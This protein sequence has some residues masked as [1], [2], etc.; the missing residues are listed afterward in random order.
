MKTQTITY[1]T[2]ASYRESLG[3]SA[4]LNFVSRELANEHI[5]KE[6]A[7][8]NWTP[9]VE[10]SNVTI[11]K[12]ERVWV[13]QEYNTYFKSDPK[14]LKKVVK[15]RVEQDKYTDTHNFQGYVSSEYKWREQVNGWGRE[16]P[17]GYYEFKTGDLTHEITET[18]VLFK[19]PVYVQFIKAELIV[20]PEIKEDGKPYQVRKEEVK[21][22]VVSDWL[23]VYVVEGGNWCSTK[24][25]I[26]PEWTD[27]SWWKGASLYVA[28][29][30][31][32]VEENKIEIVTNLQ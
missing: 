17:A 30:E 14:R 15:Q 12:K 24:Y 20:T 31:Y 29:T 16:K 7:P 13:D 3:K 28:A 32:Y 10:L 2:L 22:E 6:L 18:G 19:A 21:R 23:P 26:D 25:G 8:K 11:T 1:Y 5:I 4:D 27:G 9:N